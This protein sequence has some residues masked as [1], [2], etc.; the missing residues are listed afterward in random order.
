MTKIP[1]KRFGVMPDMSRNAV[2]DVP[3]LK[4][5]ADLI[6]DMGYNA[7]FLYIEDTYEIPGEPYFG[8]HRGRYSQDDIREIVAYCETLGMEVIPCIQTLAHLECIFKWKQYQHI[9]DTGNILLADCEET[10]ALIRKMLR[11]VASCFKSGVVHVGM[12][13][14]HMLGLGKYLDKNGYKPRFEI[15]KRHLEKVCEM[16]KEEGLEANIWAD[17]F[18][19]VSN[20]G[21]YYMKNPKV[22]P[23]LFGELPENLSLTAWDYYR[24]DR[25]LVRGMI[26][27]HQ[28]FGKD[29]WYAGGIWT[30]KGYAPDNRFSIRCSK[31]SIEESIKAGVENYYLTMWCEAGGGTS[32]F[33]G[34]PALYACARIAQGET[35]MKKIASE[36]EAKYG[37]PFARFIDLDLTERKEGLFSHGGVVTNPETYLLFNDPLLGKFD[38]SVA[39]NE[40]AFYTAYA[41]RLSKFRNHPEFGYLFRSQAA[42]AR[43]LSRKAELTVKARRAYLDG[44]KAAMKELLEKD[45]PYV[46]KHLKE[47]ITA[48][49]A[50]WLYE[51]RPQGL[52]VQEARLCG[53][54]G[55]ITSAKA[56][57]E[58]WLENGTRIPELEEEVLNFRLTVTDRHIFQDGWINHVTAGRH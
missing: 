10:Y 8:H 29:V 4:R 37:I 5:F 33:M 53:L 55:R 30:W 28:A 43:T 15:L 54:Y 2:M 49:R 19:R 20:G 16:A 12:D 24:A 23:E 45:Y 51:N 57:L 46:L 47:F 39:G 27:G 42:L 18:F 35:S 13:E 22:E 31:V 50:M 40:R 17:M 34:L 36:F 1:F 56:R 44:D 58:D 6:S 48:F 38:S 41:R 7:L 52:E 26:R 9:R 32:R 11:S 14:A 25:R 3:T 21:Q